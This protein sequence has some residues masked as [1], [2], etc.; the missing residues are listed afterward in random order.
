[1]ASAQ[2]MAVQAVAVA[3]GSAEDHMAVAM[4]RMVPRQARRATPH[5]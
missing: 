3:Q 5:Q 2:A 1:M 4:G